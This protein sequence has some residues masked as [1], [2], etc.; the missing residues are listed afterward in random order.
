MRM[1]TLILSLVLLSG[2]AHQAVTEQE[3]TRLERAWDCKPYFKPAEGLGQR[4]AAG[5]FG[6]KASFLNPECQEPNMPKEEQ[7]LLSK[8]LNDEYWRF[9]DG[10]G[11]EWTLRQIQE[12]KRQSQM[13][14]ERR[15]M[16]QREAKQRRAIAEAEAE[17]EKLQKQE[18]EKLAL[19]ERK[20]KLKNGAVQVADFTDAE[21]VYAPT[22]NLSSIMASPLLAPDNG[23]YSGAVVL[24]A[25]QSLNLL[26]GNIRPIEPSSSS[27]GYIQKLYYVFLRTSNKTTNYAPAKMR[28]GATIKVLGRYVDNVKYNTVGGEQ[29]VAP[30]IEVMYIGD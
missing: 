27:V 15:E 9:P 19:E 3:K 12:N 28:I 11:P 6:P 14:N 10:Y 29:K 8:A 20:Q 22:Q 7:E 26:R 16:I 5:Y 2:C 1:T 23:Y 13:E 18:Q 21:L 30:L 17:A 25:Q 4:I 24:D